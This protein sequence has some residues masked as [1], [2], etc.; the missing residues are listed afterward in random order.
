MLKG[1][2][3]TLVLKPQPV[4]YL[5]FP[6]PVFSQQPGGLRDVCDEPEM[7]LAGAGAEFQSCLC[8]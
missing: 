3:P 4:I 5:L 7:F 8:P 1:A 2:Y 6:C